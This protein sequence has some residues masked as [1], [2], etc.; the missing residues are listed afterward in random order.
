[1]VPRFKDIIPSVRF[2]FLSERKQRKED[3]KFIWEDRV[4]GVDLVSQT[5]QIYVKNL[6]HGTS[7]NVTGSVD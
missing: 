7:N 4:G 3:I 5:T 1:M 6:W 2:D